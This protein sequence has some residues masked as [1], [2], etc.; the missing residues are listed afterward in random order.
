MVVM[1]CSCLFCDVCAW[2]SQVLSR[3]ALADEPSGT[4]EP[5]PPPPP[6]AP[7]TY[8]AFAAAGDFKTSMQEIV[9]R[10]LGQVP[11]ALSRTAD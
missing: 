7:P 2:V 9:C 6:A 1:H 4:P 8:S 3:V 5:A 11:V 10:V